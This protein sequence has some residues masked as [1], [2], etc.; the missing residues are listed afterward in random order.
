MLAV[1]GAEVKDDTYI[2]LGHEVAYDGTLVTLTGHNEGQATLY[3][4]QR[5]ADGQDYNSGRKI[6]YDTRTG[7]VGAVVRPPTP[8]SMPARSVGSG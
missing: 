5:S 6:S 8:R 4:R 2:G 3:R 1:G 7:R